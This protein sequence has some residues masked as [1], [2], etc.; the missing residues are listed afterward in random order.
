[1]ARSLTVVALVLLVSVRLPAQTP[2]ARLSAAARGI[3][4][5]STVRAATAGAFISGVYR[6]FPM[7]DTIAI[8]ETGQPTR[9]ALV[10]VDSLWTQKRSVL[11]GA[12]IGGIIGG[13]LGG[14]FGL[15]AAH[16]ACETQACIDDKLTPFL[17]FGGAG[18]AVGG[19]IGALIGSGSRHWKRVYP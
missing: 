11:R 4:I 14:A 9:I 6:G 10:N 1:M 16:V 3:S 13:L 12:I 15:A 7:P 5:G 19:G 18:A 8:G 2:N 17:V